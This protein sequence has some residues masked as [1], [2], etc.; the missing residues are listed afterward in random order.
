MNAEQLE[1]IRECAGH[2]LDYACHGDRGRP[3]GDP[4][5][6]WVTEAR[7]RGAMRVKYS[8]CGDLAHWLLYRLGVRLSFV[9]RAEHDGWRSGVNLSLLQTTSKYGSNKLA[10]GWPGENWDELRAGDILIV[11][12]AQPHCICV[13]G[14]D[15]KDP[16]K[17][18]TAEYGQPGGKL[19]VHDFASLSKKIFSVLRLEDVLDAAGELAPIDVAPL[20]KWLTGGELDD[21]AARAAKAGVKFVGLP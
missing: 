13:I 6:D 2:L 9:N 7:D 10:A 8:S 4:V 3:E 21:L 19:K 16:T 17:L 14:F 15:S 11:K 12:I 20:E 18:H 1:I 5:Y